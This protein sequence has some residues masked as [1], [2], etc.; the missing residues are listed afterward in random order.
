MT[1]AIYLY[2]RFDESKSYA[3]VIA[4]HA[5]LKWLHTFIPY[6]VK[7]PLDM[8]V[9]RNIL[10]TAKGMK[11]EPIYKKAPVTVEI[12]QNII[13]KHTHP[14]ADLKNPRIAC[15]CSLGFAG[16]FRYS[17]LANITMSHI[18][19]EHNDTCIFAPHAKNNIYRK[20]NYA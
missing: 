12:I 1:A 15:L 10:E 20:G 16:F 5:A 3:N 14:H 7:N 11:L 6:R 4:S 2:K 18:Y 19:Y 8:P 9:C 13:A 17:E